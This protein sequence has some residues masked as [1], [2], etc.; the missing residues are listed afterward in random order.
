MLL[1]VTCSSLT[2]VLYFRLVAEVGATIAISVE[3]LVTLVAVAIGALLLHE[4]LSALQLLGG[5]I[6]ALGCALVLGIVAV[7]RRLRGTPAG[8]I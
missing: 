6:I 2:Y 8:T 4:R 7:P 3:F 5:F 1:A